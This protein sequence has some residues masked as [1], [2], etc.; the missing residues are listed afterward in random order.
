MDPSLVKAISEKNISANQ[1]KFCV[2]TEVCRILLRWLSD[3]YRPITGA[4]AAASP[5]PAK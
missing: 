2:T 1:H 5:W 3:G 4:M